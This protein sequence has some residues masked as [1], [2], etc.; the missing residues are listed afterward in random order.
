[1][2]TLWGLLFPFQLCFGAS[3]GACR[4]FCLCKKQ[5]PNDFFFAPRRPSTIYSNYYDWQNV[6]FLVAV[7][8]PV[9]LLR[10]LRNLG[11]AKPSFSATGCQKVLPA[12]TLRFNDPFDTNCS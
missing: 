12:P 5:P 3:T 8:I 9:Q 1:M 10:P 2:F 11:A 7:F 6:T 4:L